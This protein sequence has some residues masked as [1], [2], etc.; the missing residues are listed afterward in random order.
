MS[1]EQ[2]HNQINAKGYFCVV[3]FNVAVTS[4]PQRQEGK[5]LVS[6][7]TPNDFIKR[8][9]KDVPSN[10]KQWVEIVMA[11]FPSFS[12]LPFRI[13]SLPH[14]TRFAHYSL[15]DF[16]AF[17]TRTNPFSYAFAFITFYPEL[18]S[19]LLACR[20]AIS[21]DFHKFDITTDAL[22]KLFSVSEWVYQ[23]RKS[24]F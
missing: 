17:F 18:L 2:W 21:H 24:S 20:C 12:G 15:E 9:T 19:C 23:M 6:N 14:S 7:Q 22:K 3:P 11:A 8:W 1:D 4:H 10:R 5:R 13:A 16:L